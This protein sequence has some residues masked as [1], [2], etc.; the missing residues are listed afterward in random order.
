MK[1][2]SRSGVADHPDEAA[3]MSLFEFEAEIRRCLWGYENG[4]TSQGRK[5]FFKR[6][7]WLEGQREERYGVAAPRRAFRER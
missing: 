6:L 5:A 2:R 4:G 3:R 1:R 7:V